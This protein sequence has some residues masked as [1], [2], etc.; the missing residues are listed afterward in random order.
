MYRVALHRH[1]R[2]LFEYVCVSFFCFDHHLPVPSGSRSA[3]FSI[4]TDA[5]RLCVFPSLL[6]FAPDGSQHYEGAGPEAI[7]DKSAAA[8]P[9]HSQEEALRPNSGFCFLTRLK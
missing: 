9:Q 7:H 4:A 6:V 8:V 2:C 1:L 3:L 5:P